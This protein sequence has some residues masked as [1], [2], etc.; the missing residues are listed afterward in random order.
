MRFYLGKKKK[1]NKGSGV[2]DIAHSGML[3]WHVQGIGSI[4][5]QG[6]KK[7]ERKETEKEGQGGKDDGQK[8]SVENPKLLVT[9]M[10]NGW[11]AQ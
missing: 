11:E 8:M 9:P 10:E 5:L 2:Q 1:V 3:A 4:N 6:K 7:E